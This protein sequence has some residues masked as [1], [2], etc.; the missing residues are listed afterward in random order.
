METPYMAGGRTRLTLILARLVATAVPSNPI[1]QKIWLAIGLL[2]GEFLEIADTPPKVPYRFV[3]F[4]AA[5]LLHIHAKINIWL[6]SL[7]IQW[8]R[9]KIAVVTEGFCAFRREFGHAC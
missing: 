4:C 6:H 9:A 7:A 1:S 3:P 8:G 5:G 2:P